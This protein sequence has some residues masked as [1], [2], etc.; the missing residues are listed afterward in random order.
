MLLT[1]NIFYSEMKAALAKQLYI[2]IL[3]GAAV[4]SRA[5]VSCWHLIFQS[6]FFRSWRDM[7]PPSPGKTKIQPCFSTF[8]FDCAFGS[9]AGGHDFQQTESYAASQGSLSDVV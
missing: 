5:G 9:D 1:W 7:L 4:I 3:P 6:C 8:T 2:V